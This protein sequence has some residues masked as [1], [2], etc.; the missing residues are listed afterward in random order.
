LIVAIAAF[1]G[2]TIID[3][4]SA[5]KRTE[6]PA[7]SSMNVMQMMKEARKLPD[8]QFDAQ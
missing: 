8:E 1:V 2:V 7:S 4:K 6:V 3:A 5:R